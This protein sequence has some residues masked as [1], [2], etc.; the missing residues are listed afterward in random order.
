MYCQ[1]YETNKL[2]K[3]INPKEE[4]TN[5]QK[6]NK[7]FPALQLKIIA[8]KISRQLNLYRRTASGNSV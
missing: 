8:T 4:N 6:S 2:K 1:I 5:I 3:L 7:Q